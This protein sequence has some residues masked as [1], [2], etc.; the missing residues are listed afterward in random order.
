MIFSL[1]PPSPP[2]NVSQEYYDNLIRE[3]LEGLDRDYKYSAGIVDYV[4]KDKIEER[5]FI[6][7][8]EVPLTH[9]ENL[10]GRE[11]GGVARAAYEWHENVDESR[12]R[13][14]WTLQT[15]SRNAIELSN[16]WHVHFEHR[17]L[18]DVSS[19]DFLNSSF[20][21]HDFQEFEVLLR[22]HA[23]LALNELAAQERGCL[24]EDYSHLHQRGCGGV[25]AHLDPAVEPA[26]QLGAGKHEEYVDFLEKYEPVDES[27]PQGTCCGRGPAVQAQA[28]RQG[29][30][31]AGLRAL[32]L[33]RRR[34]RLQ[35]HGG[36]HPGGKGI[37]RLECPRDPAP[38]HINVLSIESD[39]VSNALD[40]VCTVLQRNAATKEAA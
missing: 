23:R 1:V 28:P 2:R 26:A 10:R 16:I 18:V 36:L 6:Q 27:T 4:V 39:A 3:S 17:L 20:T 22:A 31:P 34:L 12:E 15:L 25:T 9:L 24:Q 8:L 21:V 7:P 14:A 5:L 38:L 37:Q 11:G 32:V 40:K 35:D 33:G 19:S 13:I 30:V 29:R